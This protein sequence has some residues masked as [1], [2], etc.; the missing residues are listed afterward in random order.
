MRNP[1]MLGPLAAALPLFLCPPSHALAQRQ[2]P[3]PA[4]TATAAEAEERAA[5]EAETAALDLELVATRLEA[6][7]KEATMT[8]REARSKAIEARRRAAGARKRA[9]L[10]KSPAKSSDSALGKVPGSILRAA[11]NRETQKKLDGEGVVG[12]GRSGAVVPRANRKQAAADGE[13]QDAAPRPPAR[14]IPK[15]RD[16][17]AAAQ[18]TAD[19]NKGFYFAVKRAQHDAG[20]PK[21]LRRETMTFNPGMAPDMADLEI[22]AKWQWGINIARGGGSFQGEEGK[23]LTKTGHVDYARL[24]I[25]PDKETAEHGGMKWG[26]RRYNLGDSTVVD[27]DFENIPLEHGS[28]DNLSGHGLYRGNTYHHLGGQAIQI[29]HRD[30]AYE[31]YKADNLSFTGKPI[32]IVDDCHAVDCGE[33]SSKSGFTWTFFDYGTHENPSTIILRN[34]TSVHAWDFIR[35][36]GGQARVESSHSQ[37]TR[38]PGGMV[39]TQYQH[40]KD[41]KQGE[42]T[43]YACEYVVIDN[44][45]FDHTQNNNP[46]VAIRGAETILIE[47]SCFISRGGRGRFVDIDDLEGRPSGRVIIENCVSPKGAEVFLRVG[48]KNV[49]SMHCP[50]QRIELDLA[51]MKRTVGE[52]IDDAVTILQSPLRDRSPASGITAQPAGHE[53]DINAFKKRM[54][55]QRQAGDQA[56]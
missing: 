52:P 27:C 1:K 50:G 38:A 51:T 24:L 14:G 39:V 4:K 10:R 36:P 31:Q 54:E 25:G 5:Q 18:R 48:R 42:Q 55:S 53:D 26:M 46:I 13:A 9:N 44:C 32:V 33:H 35:T 23:R 49:M 22:R 28:Y 2:Q 47:D 29:A 6:L 30:K 41:Q 8:A 20:P 37:A 40:S 17:H 45:L 19:E 3:R 11:E 43:T 12:G 56:R 21:E 16:K 15:E 7:A 34:S